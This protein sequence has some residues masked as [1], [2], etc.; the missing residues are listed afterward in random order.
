[1]GCGQGFSPGSGGGSREHREERF[2]TSRTPF[3][4]TVVVLQTAT[5]RLTCASL[6]DSRHSER[7][8]EPVFSATGWTYRAP[9]YDD[10]VATT[11]QAMASPRPTASTPSLVLAFR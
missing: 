11:W 3:G 8:E 5:Q 4:M 2:L 7:S 10:S 1:M 9:H 6:E